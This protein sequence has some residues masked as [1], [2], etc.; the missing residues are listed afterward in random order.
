METINAYVLTEPFT[1]K[2]AG[3]SRWTFANK[4]GE[5]YFL[6]EYLS[7]VY[8]IEPTLT[9]SYREN[10]IQSCRRFELAHSRLCEE[11]SRVSDGNLIPIEEF[12]RC[13]PKYFITTRR[14]IDTGI[15]PEEFSAR[16]YRSKC[17]TMLALAHSVMCLHSA[18]IVHSDLKPDNILLEELEGG[19]LAPRLVDLG[20]A[21]FESAP[22]TDPDS[23]EGDQV[24]FSPEAVRF[25]CEE[26][27]PLT[28]RMDVFAMGLLFHHY[29]TGKLPGHSSE[30]FYCSEAVLEGEA[31]ELSSELPEDMRELIGHMVCREAE[32]RWSMQQVYEE[33]IGIMGLKA[34]EAEEPPAPDSTDT[35]E[36]AEEPAEEKPAGDWFRKAGDL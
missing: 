23:L 25:I 13:G 33:M 21:F 30:Y 19:N 34:P 29:L 22:P 9:D 20:S 16:P 18:G 7:P 6:K 15:G 3:F 14:V 10:R 32:E 27:V 1:N 5:T 26:E 8:P 31:L 28:C 36:K 4:D 12:F 17:Y 35:S 2:S 24:Y 11:V